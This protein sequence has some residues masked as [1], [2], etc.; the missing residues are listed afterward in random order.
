MSRPSVL[1]IDAGLGNIGS[2]LAAF[3]RH[4]CVVQRAPHPPSVEAEEAFT[5]A[6]LPGVG[7]F[8]AGMQA[9][10]ESGWESWIKEVWC[11]ADRPLLGI[12]L[13]MQLLASEGTEGAS[14]DGVTSGLDLIPGRVDR[15]NADPDLVL[16]HVGWN[17]LHWCK[18]S[19]AL[20]VF[21]RVVICISSTAM[22]S[23]LVIPPTV[24]RSLTMEN[25]SRL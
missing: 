21:Q 20:L 8:A 5:H 22:P 18:P 17:E 15:L 7:A 3:Q 10:K 25:S 14:K 13:G 11:E 6:V 19:S 24:W 2:V 23:F 1:V 9:L 4:D 16:P 12:C